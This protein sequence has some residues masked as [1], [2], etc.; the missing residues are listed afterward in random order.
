MLVVVGIAEQE[1]EVVAL[2]SIE[3]NGNQEAIVGLE[4]DSPGSTWLVGSQCTDPVAYVAAVTVVAAK[5]GAVAAAAAQLV[6]G[7]GRGLVDCLR[8]VG[9]LRALLAQEVDSAL[10]LQALEW[11]PFGLFEVLQVPSG[12]RQ[13]LVCHV[14]FVLPYG[15]LAC[16]S[17]G[18]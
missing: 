17:Q 9:H 5:Q 2:V 11:I 18:T 15:P 1:P 13:V 6:D 8:V 12:P 10:V 14:K 7:T 4:P 16:A 3:H